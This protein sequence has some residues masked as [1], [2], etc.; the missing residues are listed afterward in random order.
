[1]PNE[2][3]IKAVADNHIDNPEEAIQKAI[4]EKNTGDDFYTLGTTPRQITDLVGSLCDLTTGSGDN[5]TPVVLVK[6]YFDNYLTDIPER[7]RA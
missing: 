7:I 5:G 2:I 4:T 1:M 6:G 3:K